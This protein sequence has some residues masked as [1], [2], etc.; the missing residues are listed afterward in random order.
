ML[1]IKIIIFSKANLI[2]NTQWYYEIYFVKAIPVQAWTG[3]EDS[4]RLRF[5]YLK[6]VGT[7]RW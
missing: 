5:P 2:E 1:I 6:T 4:K 3:P 7:R